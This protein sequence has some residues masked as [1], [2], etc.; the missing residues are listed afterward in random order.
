[1]R[2]P[3]VAA[4][5]FVYEKDAIQ[6]WLLHHPTSPVTNLALDNTDVTVCHTMRTLIADWPVFEHERLMALS[7]RKREREE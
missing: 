1:M 6:Y 3:A 2:E 4:D 7:S 5:G